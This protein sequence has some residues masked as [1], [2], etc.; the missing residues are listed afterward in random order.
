[1]S[2]SRLAFTLAR[3]KKAGPLISWMIAHMS[4]LIPGQRLRETET[5]LAFY[6]PRPAY[7]VH[8]LLLPKRPYPSLLALPPDDTHF[9]ADLLQ[10]VQS[11]VAELNLESSGYRLITNGGPFQDVPH[12]HFHLVAGDGKMEAES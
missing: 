11:L 2:I 3:S 5:L 1:M 4:F 6:H 12:L 10:T 7:P 8:I 9:L